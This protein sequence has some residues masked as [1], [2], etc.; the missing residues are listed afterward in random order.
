VKLAARPR[1]AGFTLVELVMVIVITALV[2]V[3]ALP[4]LMDTGIWRL[5][6]F[7]DDLISQG[8]SARRMALT[9][10]RPI[11]ATISASGVSFSYASGAL[12]ASLSC[13]STVPACIAETTV[14]SVTFNNGNTG[15]A[16]TS[17]GAALDITVSNGSGYSRV[18]RVETETGLIRPLS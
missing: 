2:A 14:R 13:P 1:A 18:I 10:R 8:L 11:T 7:S 4:K 12:L 17:T 9:Q 5:R 15:S 3:V 16:L 6:A